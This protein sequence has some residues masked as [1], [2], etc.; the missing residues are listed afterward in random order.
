M[1][2]NTNSN[3]Q[4]VQHAPSGSAANPYPRSGLAL[5]DPEYKFKRG[6]MDAIA[7]YAAAKPWRGSI[8]QRLDKMRVAARN[9]ARVYG[10]AEPTIKATRGSDCYSRR[11][12]TIYINT[13]V[14]A[15]SVLTFLHE[16]AHHLGRDERGAC[17]WSI[18]LFKR[19]FPG[20]FAGLREDGHCLRRRGGSQ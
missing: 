12:A 15:P 7:A 8:P 16:F 10:V 19:A 13:T 6:V 20:S 9:L 4:R 14:G 2:H 18:N 1:S 5:V 11:D 3:T 17:R